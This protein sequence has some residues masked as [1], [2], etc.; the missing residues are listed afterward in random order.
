[1]SAGEGIVAQ[2]HEE[3]IIKKHAQEQVAL[4][5][6]GFFCL[7]TNV[8]KWVT[9]KLRKIYVVKFHIQLNLLIKVSNETRSTKLKITPFTF[10][11]EKQTRRYWVPCR[12]YHPF[13]TIQNPHL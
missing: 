7:D 4:V 6:T 9:T 8:F 12:T 11:S 3:R 1:L 13:Q 10:K 5:Q 2:S